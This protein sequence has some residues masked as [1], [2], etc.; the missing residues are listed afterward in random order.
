MQ[1]GKS[2]TSVDKGPVNK[3]T[4]TKGSGSDGTAWYPRESAPSLRG[5]GGRTVQKH[6][7]KKS[8]EKAVTPRK[9]PLGR[10]EAPVSVAAGSWMESCTQAPKVSE[11][12]GSAEAGSEGN[13]RT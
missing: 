6:Q 7:K 9:E 12:A 10:T 5:E 1:Y 8:G 2:Q 13:K 4:A 3:M 11:E